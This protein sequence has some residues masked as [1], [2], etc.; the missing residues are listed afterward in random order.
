M[1]EYGA[2]TD[3]AWAKAVELGLNRPQ[4]VGLD[5]SEVR[6]MLEA[7]LGRT[8]AGSH[9]PAKVAEWVRT[10]DDV[11]YV[12]GANGVRIVP[13]DGVGWELV[14]SVHL[15]GRGREGLGVFLHIWRRDA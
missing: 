12:G 10:Y 4:Q 3:A 9:P 13:P 15:D 11:E 7:A 8:L 2:L 5:V 1:S 14:R 6:Q